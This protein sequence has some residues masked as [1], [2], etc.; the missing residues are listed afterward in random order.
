MPT[1]RRATT[2]ATNAST[3]ETDIND[4]AKPLWNS[5]PN[6]LPPFLLK[7]GEWLMQD[8]TY[9]S[10]ITNGTVLSR[11]QVC[12]VSDNHIETVAETSSQ[13]Y[14]ERPTSHR[15]RNDRA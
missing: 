13:L 8:A 6:K 15:T 7:L 5:A 1:P 11:N 3:E 10:L 4:I 9:E 14:G 12:C 2:P